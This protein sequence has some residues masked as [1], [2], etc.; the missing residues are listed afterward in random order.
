MRAKYPGRCRYCQ[1]PIEVGRDEYDIDTN[2]SYHIE[3]AEKQ[4][5][6]PPGPEDYE[7]AHAIGFISFDPDLPADGLLLRMSRPHSGAS[8]RRP[9]PATSGR[10]PA[11]P[12]EMI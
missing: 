3:C 11:L 9:E 5:N 10:Q 12:K 1:Q 7:R 4:A 2:T 6:T 8:A